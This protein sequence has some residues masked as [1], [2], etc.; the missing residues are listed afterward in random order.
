[1]NTFLH[2]AVFNW[3]KENWRPV[4]LREWKAKTGKKGV[5]TMMND[6]DRRPP[7]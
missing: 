7:E 1:M 6:S 5:E 2:K 3:G 4:D